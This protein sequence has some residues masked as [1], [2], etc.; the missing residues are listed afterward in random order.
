MGKRPTFRDVR[1]N[2]YDRAL[3]PAL[4]RLTAFPGKYGFVQCPNGFVDGAGRAAT[5]LSAICV[6]KLR[7]VRELM[8]KGILRACCMP[9]EILCLQI[10][11]E[12]IRQQPGQRRRD[13]DSCVAPKSVGVRIRADSPITSVVSRIS[14]TPFELPTSRRLSASRQATSRCSASLGHCCR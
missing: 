13:I 5:G 12:H 1:G 11:R 10:E 14:P 2:T 6:G 4:R 3:T 7:F 9:V 8:P